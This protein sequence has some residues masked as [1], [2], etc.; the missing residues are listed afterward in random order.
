MY[1]AIDFLDNGKKNF[2]TDCFKVNENDFNN[3]SNDLP[4]FQKFEAYTLFLLKRLQHSYAAEFQEAEAH[5][6][7]VLRRL[8]LTILII[9]SAV[10]YILFVSTEF[11]AHGFSP[12]V[13]RVIFYM[14]I[15]FF[16]LIF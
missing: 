14:C 5:T 4:E 13:V 2:T 7:M 9:Q 11:D 8:Q 3:G 10:K 1:T 6:P 15:I 12:H 16:L